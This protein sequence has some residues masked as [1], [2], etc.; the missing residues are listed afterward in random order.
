MRSASFLDERRKTRCALDKRQRTN[1]FLRAIRKRYRN[2]G[3]SDIVDKD[4]RTLKG[5]RTL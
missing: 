2:F 5:F 3:L 4:V 1:D